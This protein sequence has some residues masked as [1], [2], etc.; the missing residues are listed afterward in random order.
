[1]NYIEFIGPSAAGKTTLLNTLTSSRNENNQWKTYHEAI[2]DIVNKLDW[3]Q[4]KTGKSKL[5]YLL[6]KGN[7]SQYKKVGL[8]NTIIQELTKE[9]ADPV[10]QKYEYLIEAQLKAIQS[11]QLN[12]SPINKCSLLNWHLQS[13]Q[14][15]FVLEHFN[16]KP[17]VLLTEGPFKTHYGLNNINLNDIRSDTLP[18]AVIY[19]TLNLEKNL[20]R[21]KTRKNKTGR[22]SKIHSDLKHE[23]LER[24][25]TYTHEIATRN[26]I[27]VKSIGIPT[28]EVDL[29][30]SLSSSD[31][32]QL[33]RFIETYST[34][35][36]KKMM[37]NYAVI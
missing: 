25:V 4:M 5:L 31:L 13:L 16:Y 24:M 18:K 19:C 12:I 3:S 8:S 22:L 36:Q 2:F 9:I 15:I 21:I 28:I 37:F 14:K 26:F 17:T 10:Q 33:N 11:L 34:T 1:M 6:N 32:N 30:L 7:I 29:S 35:T 27:F 20:N 23:S